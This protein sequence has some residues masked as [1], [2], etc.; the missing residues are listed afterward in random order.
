MWIAPSPSALASVVNSQDAVGDGVIRAPQGRRY[1]SLPP[2]R[3]KT[4]DLRQVV[5]DG[6]A[7]ASFD[8]GSHDVVT[9][10]VR[11]PQTLSPP[12]P[13]ELQMSAE[14]G[15]YPRKRRWDGPPSRSQ[16]RLGL[17][18]APLRDTSPSRLQR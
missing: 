10:L 17:G 12:W 8:G 11:D 4:D 15:R 7:S 2:S 1:W 18:P 14:E 3:H 9:V 16:R 13:P 6:T 5:L